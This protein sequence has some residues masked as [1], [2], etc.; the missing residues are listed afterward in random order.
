[1]PPFN[2]SFDPPQGHWRC[3]GQRRGKYHRCVDRASRHEGTGERSCCGL[4]E[5][6]HLKMDTINGSYTVLY[7]LHSRDVCDYAMTGLTCTLPT[8]SKALLNNYGLYDFMIWLSYL[9]FFRLPHGVEF[10]STLHPPPNL[11]L[12]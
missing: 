11:G 10:Q 1:M 8:T 4:S 12:N 7:S 9:D 6:R 2:P 3:G 5:K